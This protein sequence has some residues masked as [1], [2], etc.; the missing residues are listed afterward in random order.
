MR[1][2]E[3]TFKS[4]G[5]GL[6]SQPRTSDHFAPHM[7]D[8]VLDREAVSQADVGESRNVSGI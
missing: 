5:C 6:K 2:F 4:D 3:A 8:R 1:H 7:M